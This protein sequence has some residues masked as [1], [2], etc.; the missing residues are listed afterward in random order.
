MVY[1]KVGMRRWKEAQKAEMGWWLEGNRAKWDMSEMARLHRVKYSKLMEKIGILIGAGKNDKVLD[2]GCGPS[3]TS[4]YFPYGKKYGVDPLIDEFRKA[5]YPLPKRM[6]FRKGTGE[7]IPFRKGFF[8]TV[9]CLNAIDHSRSPPK[10]I[11]ECA[12]VLKPEGHLILEV[13]VHNPVTAFALKTAESTRRFRQEPHPYFFTAKELFG[14]VSRR[15]E[16]ADV[17]ISE[18][19]QRLQIPDNGSVRNRARAALKKALVKEYIIVGKVKK[20]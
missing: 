10:V 11:D 6:V 4:M 20:Q 12:R 13:Y 15:F 2:L 8:D 3:C 16:I 1:S 7:S 9:M 5:G 14:L 17:I 18:C 19:D